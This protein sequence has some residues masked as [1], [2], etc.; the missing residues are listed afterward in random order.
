MQIRCKKENPLRFNA[1]KVLRFNAVRVQLT[2]DFDQSIDS[3]L[4]FHARNLS[5]LM[6]GSARN[7]LQ[8]PV[9]TL[10]NMVHGTACR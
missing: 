4:R 9:F 5:F 1:V 8:P 10:I 6:L 3:Y 7:T 2:K